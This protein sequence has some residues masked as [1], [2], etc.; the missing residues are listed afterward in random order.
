MIQTVIDGIC[1]TLNT[2]FGDS[3]AI[4]TEDVSQGLTTP[5]FFIAALSPSQNYGA[6]GRYVRK[7]P[8]DIH[9]FPKPDTPYADMYE[10]ASDLFEVLEFITLEN[11]DKARAFDMHYQIIDGILHFF[12]RYDLFLQSVESVDGM[13]TLDV[14][15]NIMKG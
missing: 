4:Y 5:C 12:V 10:M 11:G 1:L 14:Q 15:N 6:S 3:Y 13:D 2:H 7:H 8:V 9:Y